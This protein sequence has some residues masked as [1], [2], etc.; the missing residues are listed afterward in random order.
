[1]KMSNEEYKFLMLIAEA[2]DSYLANPG[3]RD[4]YKSG[5]DK[6]T[7]RILP[8]LIPTYKFTVTFGNSRDPYIMTIRPDI[9]EL[10][11]KANELFAVLNDPNRHSNEYLERWAE[12]K[13]WELSIDP[14][15][16]TKGTRLCV[17]NGRQFAAILCHELGHVFNEDPLSLVTNYRMAMLRA[18]KFEK[19]M[20]SRSVIVRKLAMPMFIASE[21]F[22]VIVEKPE[23]DKLEMAADAYCP[24]ELRGELLYY[25][26]NHMLI[27]PAATQMVQTREEY[28]A[29]QN[30]AISYARGTIDLMQKRRNV[31][32]NQIKVQFDSD[33]N[34]L[35]TRKL[36]SVL[37][38]SLGQYDPS[39]DKIDLVAESHNLHV[40]EGEMRAVT[41]AINVMETI[42]VTDRK[43]AMLTVD[44][45]NIK[46]T[47]D[48]LY[49]LQ[50]VYDY[51]DAI[52]EDKNR[53]VKRSGK[54][55]NVTADDLLSLDPRYAKLQNL[56]NTIMKKDA[57]DVPRSNFGIFVQY[58]TGY[59][60]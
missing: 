19:M 58:P 36:M 30:T 8:R 13:T 40:F 46:T 15:I 2:V 27:S 53:V 39:T 18:S 34:D 14:R 41:E 37:G 49:C 38:K 1:M 32:R 24:P 11:T 7:E 52:Q 17:D 48:K 10:S 51:L 25:I 23:K 9:E 22:R 54:H 20:L 50:T 12:I 44:V 56:R 21:S 31:L 35:Y 3:V 5:V 43:I 47:D 26:D 45:D 16:L 55:A 6:R 29:N 33:K 60:G 59:E 28:N 4:P 42:N 57:A